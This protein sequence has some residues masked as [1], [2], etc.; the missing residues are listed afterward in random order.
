MDVVL[1][2]RPG[3]SVD[4]RS[5]NTRTISLCLYRVIGHRNC[6]FGACRFTLRSIHKVSPR[7]VAEFGIL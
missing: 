4:D 5:V 7:I 3:E 1:R 6:S 2:N